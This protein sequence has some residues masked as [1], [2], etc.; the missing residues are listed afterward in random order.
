MLFHGRSKTKYI[1][2]RSVLGVE[3]SSCCDLSVIITS[4]TV[5]HS[6]ATWDHISWVYLF[7]H[8]RHAWLH[9]LALI[10]A[11][12]AAGASVKGSLQA[13]SLIGTG[14]RA[15]KGLANHPWHVSRMSKCWRPKWFNMWEQVISLTSPCLF[16]LQRVMS[17][18][19]CLD[20]TS[21]RTS[22]ASDTRPSSV[23]GNHLYSTYCTVANSCTE[24]LYGEG[25]TCIFG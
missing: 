23:T 8:A 14:I 18:Q 11:P 16:S 12:A 20:R 22:I 10:V 4:C 17:G 13:D 7:P 3:T 25:G 1:Y 21:S 9:F 15:V 5:L 19:C 2:K 6:V 24:R